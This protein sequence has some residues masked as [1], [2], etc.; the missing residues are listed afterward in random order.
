[1][2]VVL[3]IFLMSGSI[4]VSNGQID[5]LACYERVSSELNAIIN[6]G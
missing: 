6:E 5:R 4:L 2:A 1:M 3:S